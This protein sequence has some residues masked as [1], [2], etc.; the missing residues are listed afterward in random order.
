MTNRISLPIPIAFQYVT[1]SHTGK[2]IKSQFDAI[3]KEFGLT[4][5]TYKFVADQ[6][7]NMRN[8]FKDLEEAEDV[9]N[10]MANM[11][12]RQENDEKR[13]FQ[14]QKQI[15]QQSVLVNQINK[16]LEKENQPI[17]DSG[18]GGRKRKNCRRIGC[19]QRM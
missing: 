19:H 15:D 6:A 18:D 12:M 13:E 11:M 14:T 5:K 8:A 10:T 9:V 1:G 2:A 17:D 16:E 3:Q 4:N 7:A